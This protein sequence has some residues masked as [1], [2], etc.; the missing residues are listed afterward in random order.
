MGLYDPNAGRFDLAAAE[1]MLKDA[2][3]DRAEAVAHAVVA[4]VD[5]L[6][7]A[8]WDRD[9]TSAANVSPSHYTKMAGW[10]AN[11]KRFP[12]PR[13]RAIL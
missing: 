7:T 4:A 2:R 1:A 13:N 3:D 11:Q 10:V 5:G 6:E 12:R 9:L 8:E